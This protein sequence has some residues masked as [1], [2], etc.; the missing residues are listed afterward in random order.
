MTTSAS[1]TPPTVRE[2][3][4]VPLGHHFNTLEQEHEASEFGMWIFLM[5]ELMFFG[6]LFVAYIFYR[7]VYSDGF[8]EG[9]RHLELS[10]G[11]PNTVILIVSS[12]TMV[13][14]VRSAQLGAQRRLF[15][16]L[17][18]TAVLGTIFMVIKGAEYYQHYLDG[19]V[20]GLNWTYAGPYANQVQ[21]FFFAY[22]ALTGLHSIHLTIGI[23]VVLV[24]AFMARRGA[25]LTRH[26]VPVEMM[27][28][29]WHFVDIVW[30]F[31][32]PLL[33]LFGFHP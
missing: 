25:F 32:L 30:M 33:Y 14:A 26:H 7:T 23:C 20:P 4:G 18:A 17:I 11:G 21:L 2:R 3:E 24:I 28:L 1:S 8:A 10:Y 27:G 13:L 22:F 12:L 19:E 31:L 6:A 29:Y 15:W 5:T 9:S 16:Y